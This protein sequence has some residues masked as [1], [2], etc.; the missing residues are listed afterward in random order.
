MKANPKVKKRVKGVTKDSAAAREKIIAAGIELFAAQGYRGASTESIAERAGY[1]QATVFF[2]FKTKEGLLKACL[3]QKRNDLIVSGKS[4]SEPV[5]TIEALLE[6]DTRFADSPTQAFFSRILGDVLDID[7][8][9]PMYSDFHRNL[10][11]LIS[12]ELAHETGAKR[13]DADFA[14][15][16]LLCMMIGV[17]VEYPVEHEKYSRDQYTEM[18]TLTAKLMLEHL[19]KMRK[20]DL[21]STDAKRSKDK[22]AVTVQ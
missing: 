12:K 22:R 19:K 9:R 3:E 5:G 10:R 21:K 2:H 4:G 8:I 16:A 7:S 11:E 1:G 13:K 17:H 20:L 6:I 14:A 18:L 15:S